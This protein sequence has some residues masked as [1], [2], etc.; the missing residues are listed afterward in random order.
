M[1]KLNP[2]LSVALC[3]LTAFLLAMP[4]CR[5]QVFT[6]PVSET[7]GN[8]TVTVIARNLDVPWALAFLPDGS[9]IFTERPGKVRLIDAQGGLL[10]D[11]LAL[12]DGAVARGE[13]GLLGIALHPDFT[14][15]HLVYLYYTYEASSGAENRVVSYVLEDNT[16]SG[17]KVIIQGI[18]AGSVHDGGRI[19]FGPDGCLYVTCGDAGNAGNAQDLGSLA[20]K[21]LRLNDDGSIPADNPFPGSPVYSYGHRN[22]QG[23]AWDEQGRLWETEHGNSAHDE[24]NLIEPGHNYGW[25]IIQGD[26]TA[27]GMEKPVINSGGDTWAPSGAAVR[28]NTFF[29]AGLR[30]ESL[31]S[32]SLDGPD[33]SNLQTYFR[34]EYGRLRDVVAA[35]DG[36]LYV[37]TCNTDGRGSPRA[38]DDK[39]LK[40]DPEM[41]K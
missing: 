16:L 37:F 8:R 20:G 26:Q 17:E 11:P 33:I 38:N 10:P 5:G 28:G 9:I 40:I 3:L 25:P 30:G 22:P 18:P 35:P 6:T 2:F 1:K 39:L 24:V 27:N 4:S 7:Q 23:L 21:I 19:K 14:R 15:N 29:Y 41:L 13:S 34:G 31:F 12:I 32:L 36:F